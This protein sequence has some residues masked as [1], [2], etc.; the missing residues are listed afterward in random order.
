MLVIPIREMRMVEVTDTSM[1]STRYRLRKNR[2]FGMDVRELE[3]YQL[4]LKGCISC[5]GGTYGHIL[6]HCGDHPG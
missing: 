4:I 6:V 5:T 1:A 2:Y 3:V